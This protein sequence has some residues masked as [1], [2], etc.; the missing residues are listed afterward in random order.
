M[1]ILLSIL[2]APINLQLEERKTK[3]NTNPTTNFIKLRD[4]L[5]DL[6]MNL[7]FKK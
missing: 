6:T 3:Q 4:F 2:R 1:T 7:L 5:T